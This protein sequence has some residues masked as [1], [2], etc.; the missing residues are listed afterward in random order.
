MYSN[1]ITPPDFTNEDKHTVTVI[2]ATDSEIELLCR[3]AQNSIED[4]NIYLYKSEMSNA[5]WLSQAINLS[6]SIIVNIDIHDNLDIFKNEKTYYYGSKTILSPA[7]K[8][9]SILDY[10][11]MRQIK[12]K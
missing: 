2:D 10:F 4:Y 8:I 11:Q 12:H 7:T 5:N 9:N 6:E 1:F 3:V